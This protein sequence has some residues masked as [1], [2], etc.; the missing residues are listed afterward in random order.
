MKFQV[1]QFI[2]TEVKLVGPFTL[3]QFLWVA[4]GA[5]LIYILYLSLPRVLFFILGIPAGALCGSF[6]FVTINGTPLISYVGYA[7]NYALNSKKY[8]YKK[9]EAPDNYSGSD[10]LMHN[11]EQL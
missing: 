3:K 1:P 5:I 9:F 11:K 7:I 6:A 2:E 8:I 10:I 4:F